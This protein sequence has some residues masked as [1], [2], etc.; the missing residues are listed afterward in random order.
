MGDINVENK[1]AL[2]LLNYLP[3]CSI[4]ILTVYSVYQRYRKW[5]LLKIKP[6]YRGKKQNKVKGPDA[7]FIV[8]LIVIQSRLFVT[9][10]FLFA[11]MYCLFTGE[12][13][14]Q[15]V[16]KLYINCYES[17]HSPSYNSFP[18]NQCRIGVLVGCTS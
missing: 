2:P 18:I 6:K 4:F 15:T 3:L 1:M 5:N 7:K 17:I 13:V 16:N 8:S 9:F 14:F 10:F 12:S 11:K